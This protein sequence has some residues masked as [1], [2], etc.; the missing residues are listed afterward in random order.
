MLDDAGGGDEAGLHLPG[1]EID[2]QRRVAAIRHLHGLEAGHGA[3]IFHR[4]MAAAAGTGMGIG[5]RL[6]FA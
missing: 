4:Q 1:D 2:H 3:E 5:Q 6:L